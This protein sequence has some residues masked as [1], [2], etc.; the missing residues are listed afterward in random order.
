MQW[1]TVSLEIRP[2]SVS[3]NEERSKQKEKKIIDTFLE[4]I[5][6]FTFQSSLAEYSLSDMK[7]EKVKNMQSQSS[8]TVILLN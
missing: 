3:E 7:T 1:S 6:I 8:D 2:R 4:F 5:H